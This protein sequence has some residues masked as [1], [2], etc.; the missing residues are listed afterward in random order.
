MAQTV[1]NPEFPHF[2]IIRRY[3]GVT[4]FTVPSPFATNSDE[5]DSNVSGSYEETVVYA[6]CCRR[7]SSDNIR[8]FRTGSTSVGQVNY[9]DYRISIPGMISIAKGDTVTVDYRIGIDKG[10][11][12]IHPNWSSLKTK[13]FP[14]GRTE[15]YYNLADI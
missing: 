14:N 8:T 5:G 2:C 13:K 12:V 1:E 15:F 7:E 11:T 3:D 10:A 6:G 4:P 9:G